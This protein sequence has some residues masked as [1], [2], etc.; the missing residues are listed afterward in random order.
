MNARSQ[1]KVA[2]VTAANRGIGLACAQALAQDG[3]RVYLAVRRLAA[4]EEI[5]RRWAREGLAGGVCLFNAERPDTFSSSV[6]EVVKKE[7]RLDILV[8]N[9]GSTDPK[10]DLDLLHTDPADFFAVLHSNL[11]SVYETSR[12]AV[13]QMAR[14]GS[15]SIVNIASVGGRFPDMAR[16]AYGVSKSAIRFLTRNIAVQYAKAGV[17]ANCVLPGFIATDAALQNMSPAFLDAF[18][19]TVPLGRAGTA[20]EVAQAC[21]FFATDRSAFLTGEELC[22]SGGFGLPSPMYSHYESLGGLG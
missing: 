2:M 17:R 6:E 20:E 21:L 15:G 13:A 18:L 9:Y 7:G 4:G 1:G 3:C 11:G 10:K 12:A 8:N 5:L 14:Q 19:K 16:I 22:V